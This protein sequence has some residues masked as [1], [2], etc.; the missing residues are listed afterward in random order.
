VRIGVLTNLRAGCNNAQL[1]RVLSF[2]KGCAD[3]LHVETANH[4]QVAEALAVLAQHRPDILVVNGG[5]G[6]LQHSLT[7]ILGNRTL[8]WFPL[9]APLRGG[10]TNMNALDIG[11][12][13]DPVT[14]LSTLV[15]A[16]GNGS[17]E[18]RIVERPVLRIDLGLAEAIQYGMFF[19]VGVIH[20]TIAL[21]HRILPKKHLQGLLGAAAFTSTLVARAVLGSSGG[22]LTPDTMKIWLDGQ[23]L[24]RE[25]FML[26][27]A[28]SLERLFLNIRPFWGQEPAPIRFTA[29][30]AGA[31]RTPLAAL[32]ILHGSGPSNGIPVPGYTSRNIHRLDLSL[33]CGVLVDGELFA[34]IPGRTVR[35]TADQR[36][37]FVRT[38]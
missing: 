2:L 37:R 7:A 19:G 35:I 18:K 28:T 32:R 5:D 20:R 16:A 24:E 34:P 14:A 4:A 38:D 1:G 13:R 12:H 25:Q 30:A 22:L 17:L 33:D 9:I 29:I 31:P 23:P 15:T 3:T 11:S 8:P 26:V 27:M 36:V 6:T 21:K 10:R